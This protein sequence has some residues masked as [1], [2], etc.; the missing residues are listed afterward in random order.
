MA[1]SSPSSAASASA[2]RPANLALPVDQELT[3]RELEVVEHLAQGL[4]NSEIA[5]ELCIGER[6]VKAHLSSIM[7]K[8]ESRDRVQVLIKASRMGIVTI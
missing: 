3:G 4:P 1:I 5:R 2:G 6:T 7:T 8:W